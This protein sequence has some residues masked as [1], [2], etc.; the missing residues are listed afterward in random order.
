MAITGADLKAARQAAKLGQRT[1]AEL[2]GCSVPHISLIEKGERAPSPQVIKA[3]KV[4][5]GE[6]ITETDSDQDPAIVEAMRRRA[7]IARIAAATVGGLAVEPFLAFLDRLP[8]TATPT[9]V[10]ETDIIAVEQATDWLTRLDL[11]S[12]GGIA[13]SMAD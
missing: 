5:T 1:I 2:A 10:G 7:M 4:A 8:A 6:E 11:S 12:G 9:R 3:Y 13:A